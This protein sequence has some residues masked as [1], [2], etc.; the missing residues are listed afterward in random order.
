MV[1][2]INLLLILAIFFWIVFLSLQSKNYSRFDFLERTEGIIQ[3]SY[4]T[5]SIKQIDSLTSNTNLKF[6][7]IIAE[8]IKIK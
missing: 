4:N 3:L 2:T 1:K 5:F 6:S 8:S 7:E